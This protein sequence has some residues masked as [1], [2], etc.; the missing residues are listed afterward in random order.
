MDLQNSTEDPETTE[1]DSPVCVGREEDIKKSQR[2][3]AIV[4]DREIVIFYHKG[5]YHAMD[6]RCYRKIFVFFFCGYIV[7][8]KLFLLTR[9]CIHLYFRFRRTFTFGRDRGPAFYPFFPPSWLSDIS[10]HSLNTY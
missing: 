8:L 9:C 6:I 7:I 5:E 10:V 3:T 1:D 2:M 4:H